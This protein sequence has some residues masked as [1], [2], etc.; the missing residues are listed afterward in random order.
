MEKIKKLNRSF[1]RCI[2]DSHNFK[3]RKRD[4]ANLYIKIRNQRNDWLSK[5]ARNLS[6]EYDFISIEDLY[7]HY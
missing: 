4:L 5:T 7:L 1:S 2:K 3:K 6:L